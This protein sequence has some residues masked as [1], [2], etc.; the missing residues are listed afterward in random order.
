MEPL[1]TAG[2]L[3]VA[4]TAI[5][6][7]QANVDLYATQASTGKKAQDLQGYGQTS[8]QVT[9]AQTLA[10]RISGYLSNGSIIG[11]QLQLQDTTL[12]QVADA[13]GTASKAVSSALAAGD[14]AT[15]MTQLQSAFSQSVSALNT[16]Y[17]G[18]YLYSG[19]NAFTQPVTATQLS[20]LTAVASVSQ[21]FTNG[22]LQTVSRFDDNTQ[23][24]T[25]QTASNV[26]TP[27]FTA[28]QQIEAYN[29]SA[30]GPFGSPLTAAQTT[31]LQGVV[32]TLNTA[33]SGV[34]AL[35]AQNGAVQNQLT[36]STDNLTAQQTAL[37]VHMSDLT[38]V[39]IAQVATS[40]SLAQTALQASAQVF[41]TLKSASLLNYLSSSTTSG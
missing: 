35:A 13:A 5:Q 41:S 38:D 36:A 21:V 3:L 34:T 23:A 1:S 24:V 40:L 39:D 18:Q 14:G 10:S 20:D 28:L 8:A 19:G 37:K 22:S 16:Q 29:Q 7:A 27:L 33:Q 31:F 30:N 4:S 25:G 12:N 2:R 32:S 17:N 11:G 15:L 9:A 26:G 6:N